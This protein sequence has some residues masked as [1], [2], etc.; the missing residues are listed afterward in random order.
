MASEDLLALALLQNSSLQ[1]AIQKSNN[2]FNI[3]SDTDLNKYWCATPP[4]IT[5]QPV[6][7]INPRENTTA[8]LSCKVLSNE[9]TSYKWKKNDNE[10]PNQKNSTLVLKMYNFLTVVTTP[11]RL[12]I[13]WEL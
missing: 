13:M 2:F 6:L 4:I 10:L 5:E 11:V 12:Q 1:L 3:I 8:K 7:G 9:Y